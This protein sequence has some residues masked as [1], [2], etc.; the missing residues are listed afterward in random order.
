M[1]TSVVT[2]ASRGFGRAIAAALVAEGS[3]VVGIARDAAALDGVH[4]EL[5]ERFR[6]VPGDATDEELAERTIADEHPGLLVLNAGATP[7]M[8]P[9]HE[10]TWASF[11][12]IWENDTRHV[13]AWVRAALRAPLAPGSVVVLMS[14]G[15]VVAGSPQSGGYASAKAAIRFIGRYAGEESA[16]AGLGLRFVTLLPQLT[17]ATALG[18]VGVAGYAERGGVDRDTVVAGLQPV[19][20]PEQLA[21]TV[22]DLTRNPDAAAEYLVSGAG[23][24]RLDGE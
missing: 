10:Q 18:S 13:F 21:K 7:L 8:A 22:V 11:S 2:G 15:A 9:V 19:L 4:A 6:A 5:G 14:S 12:R 20:T 3:D 1:P 16:R 24:R 23:V 17:P